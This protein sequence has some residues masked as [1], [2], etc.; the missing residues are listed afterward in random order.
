MRACRDLA[1][2][3]ILGFGLLDRSRKGKCFRRQWFFYLSAIN[4]DRFIIVGPLP[5]RSSDPGALA[6]RR[7]PARAHAETRFDISKLA[8]ELWAEY[9]EPVEPPSVEKARL[10]AAT[11]RVPIQ[12]SCCSAVH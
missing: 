7:H 8:D 3:Q 9:L 12:I 2:K 11:L 4:E 10:A 1:R 6:E 5:C